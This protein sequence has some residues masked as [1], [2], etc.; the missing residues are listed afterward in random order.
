MLLKQNSVETLQMVSH[1]LFGELVED[2]KF[3]S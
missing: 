2:A 3:S 1:I